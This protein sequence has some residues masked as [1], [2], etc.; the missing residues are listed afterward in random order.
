MRASEIIVERCR[1]LRFAAD[2]GK[3]EAMFAA[4]NSSSN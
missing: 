1:P 2:S 3:M 4:I